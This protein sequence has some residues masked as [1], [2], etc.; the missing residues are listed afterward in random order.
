MTVAQLEQLCD[1]VEPVLTYLYSLVSDGTVL[2]E[3]EDTRVL[4]VP[5]ATFLV[6]VC[7]VVPT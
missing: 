1:V 2:P 7:F 4:V 3:P 6:V 5:A